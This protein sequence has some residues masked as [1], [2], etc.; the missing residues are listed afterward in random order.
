MDNSE[1]PNTINIFHSVLVSIKMSIMEDRKDMKL[2]S[3]YYKMAVFLGLAP[4]RGKE[5]QIPRKLFYKIFLGVLIFSVMVWAFLFLQERVRIYYKLSSPPFLIVDIV[6]NIIETLFICSCITLNEVRDDI[7]QHSL[8]LISTIENDFTNKNLNLY[9]KQD[10]IVMCIFKNI[11]CILFSICTHLFELII[12]SNAHPNYFFLNFKIFIYFNEI[13][14]V[15]FIHKAMRILKRRYE[16]L[17]DVLE[18]VVKNGEKE[19]DKLMELGIVYQKLYM[20]TQNFNSL[21]G[22]PIFFLLFCT[23]F[24]ILNCLNGLF[25]FDTKSIE[26]WKVILLNISF[27]S[28]YLVSIF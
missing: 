7:W 18:E 24:A 4:L 12:L 17:N 2:F 9:K 13:F 26:I 27:A 3:L 15:G 23:A 10:N 22:W 5:N 14:M 28:I 20:L 21:F 11:I 25:L 16:L 6:Q 19:V 8:D 1:F